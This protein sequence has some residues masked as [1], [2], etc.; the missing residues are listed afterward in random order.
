[1]NTIQFYALPDEISNF[2]CE[3]QQEFHFYIVRFE[4]QPWCAKLIAT[5]DGYASALRLTPGRY[6]LYNYM[7]DLSIEKPSDFRDKNTNAI[8]IDIAPLSDGS[9]DESALSTMADEED[10]AFAQAKKI[11]YKLKKITKAGVMF[12]NVELDVEGLSRTHRY[13]NGVQEKWAEGSLRLISM[14]REG[15]EVYPKI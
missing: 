9:L 3:V 8:S 2:I 10:I 13:S 7:P 11:A 6:N 4:Y 14:G 1:M 15:I 12:K 5:K